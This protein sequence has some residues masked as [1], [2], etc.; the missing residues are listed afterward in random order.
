MNKLYYCVATSTDNDMVEIIPAESQE[1]AT[2]K[3]SKMI[4][5]DDNWYAGAFVYELKIDGYEISVV[6]TN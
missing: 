5:E 6:K 3:F 1:E 4:E 2:E